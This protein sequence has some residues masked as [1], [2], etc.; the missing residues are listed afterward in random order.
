MAAEEVAAGVR[1]RGPQGGE[2]SEEA[3]TLTNEEITMSMDTA[4]A[5]IRMADEFGWTIVRLWGVEQAGVCRCPRGAACPSPGKHPVERDWGNAATSDSEQIAVAFTD[6]DNIGVVVGPKSGVIDVEYDTPE[7]RAAV[8][9]A[10]KNVE[11]VTPTY[12]SGRSVHRLFKW[13]DEFP[14]AAKLDISGIEFRLGADGRAAQ[15]VLPPSTHHTGVQYQW[16]EGMSPWDCAVAPL[17]DRLAA[18]LVNFAAGGGAGMAGRPGGEAKINW[19]KKVTSIIKQTGRNN[20]LF[21]TACGLFRGSFNCESEEDVDTVI[22]LLRSVNTTQCQPPIE[23]G[24]VL[25]IVR[26]AIAQRRKDTT[27]H[28]CA[29]TG[30]RVERTGDIVEFHPDSL[31]LT[32][33]TSDPV[34]YRLHAPSWEAHTDRHTGIVSLSSEQFRNADKVADA[35][36]E[37]TRVVCLDRYPEEWTTV[38]D[39]RKAG[40]NSPPVFGLKGKLLAAARDAGRIIDA[41]RSAKRSVVLAQFIYERM[42]RA[43][44]PVDG[45]KPLASGAPQRMSDGSIW[46]RWEWLWSDIRKSQ[47]TVEQEKRVMQR[48][49]ESIFGA[50]PTKRREVAGGKLV[51][52]VWGQRELHLLDEYQAGG[53]DDGAA[54]AAAET[55]EAGNDG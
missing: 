15:S 29:E 30:I 8:E 31:E 19:R 38:W 34:E 13:S 33:V 6:R 49:L 44:P 4:T 22:R 7:G 26:N 10:L 50:W 45:D 37:Q 55:Q 3:T 24:E 43:R 1:V 54:E 12:R 32:I 28:L 53:V 2:G 36:L 41:P 51:Y 52:C 17:P 39:G 48:R 25:D 18:M 35:V 20:T 9:D 11:F 47:G 14:R 21:S 40:K 5:A 16:V 42:L 23:D 46:F 27:S